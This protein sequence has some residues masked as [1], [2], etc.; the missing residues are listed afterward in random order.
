M[1]V[2]V[3]QRRICMLPEKDRTGRGSFNSRK[4]K[5]RKIMRNDRKLNLATGLVE[6]VMMAKISVSEQDL[7]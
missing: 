2:R 6:Q 5:M 4:L 1:A 7:A 3:S